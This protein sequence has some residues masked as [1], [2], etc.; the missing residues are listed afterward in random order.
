MNI[1]SEHLYEYVL[2]E[3]SY[4]HLPNILNEGLVDEFMKNTDTKIRK[5]ILYMILGGMLGISSIS[6]ILNN[7][8]NNKEINDQ[9]T[10]IANDYDI[11]IDELSKQLYM[12][13]NYIPS[14]EKEEKSFI[15]NMRKGI[16]KDN[17]KENSIKRKAPTNIPS[18][19]DISKYNINDNDLAPNKAERAINKA[20]IPSYIRYFNW[21]VKRGHNAPSGGYINMKDIRLSNE[22]VKNIMHEEKYRNYG[23]K[24]ES[25]GNIVTVGFGTAFNP[26]YYNP[27]KLKIPYNYNDIVPERKLFVYFYGQLQ[28]FEI[29][30]AKAI[31]SGVKHNKSM[32]YMP[33]SAVDA[34]ISYAYTTGPS[35]FLKSELGKAVAS[36]NMKKASHYI[37]Y[38]NI[39]EEGHKHRREREQKMFNI[40]LD[41]NNWKEPISKDLKN[42]I[43]KQNKGV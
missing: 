32:V 3:H 23:Y 34:L 31:R 30:V 33:Q 10:S 18:L 9:I 4:T 20:G 21:A 24:A 26:K 2:Y 17:N 15:D 22:G 14:A 12:L 40:N 28:E 35:G 29:A 42:A 8:S 38:G 43:L 25:K 16:K 7:I 11:N 19:S 41:G 13:A 37:R 5:K 27:K 1:I 6:P 36:G 39:T